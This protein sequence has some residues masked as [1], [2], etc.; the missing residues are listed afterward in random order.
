[1]WVLCY[2][3]QTNVAEIALSF[4]EKENKGTSSVIIL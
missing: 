2:E 4:S 3:Q 1:M